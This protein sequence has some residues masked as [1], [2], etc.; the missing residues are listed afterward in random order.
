MPILIIT[1]LLKKERKLMPFELVEEHT[2][3]HT[4]HKIRQTCQNFIK[5]M[6]MR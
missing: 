2:S 1:C 6:Y 5:K 4:S 3:L